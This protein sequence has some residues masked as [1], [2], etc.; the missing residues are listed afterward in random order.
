MEELLGAIPLSKF[1]FMRLFKRYSGFSPYEYVLNYRI[2]DSK[3]LLK[4]SDLS[5]KEIAYQVGFNDVN[6]YIREF[7]KLVGTTPVKYRK[8]WL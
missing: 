1:H 7:K 2:H 3:R 8:L 5:V 6:N 4:E